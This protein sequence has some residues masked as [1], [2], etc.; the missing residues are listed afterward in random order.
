MIV[1][2]L[3]KINF[4]ECL[5]EDFKLETLGI[6]KKKKK[7]EREREC[8]ITSTLKEYKIFQ[9]KQVKNETKTDGYLKE[10]IRN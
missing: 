7:R 9:Q 1:H 8:S 3:Q 4:I 6:C 2:S 10:A 5:N